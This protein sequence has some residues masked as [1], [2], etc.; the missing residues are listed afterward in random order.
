MKL[1]LVIGNIVSTVKDPGLHGHKFLLLQPLTSDGRK[2]GRIVVAVDS[3]GSGVGE[4]VIFVRG[5]EASFPF[6]PELV[7]IDASVVGIVDR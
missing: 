6:L 1:A 7:P 2:V 5:R 4:E 3:V